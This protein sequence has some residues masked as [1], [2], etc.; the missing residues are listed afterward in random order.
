M[1]YTKAIYF[2]IDEFFRE[3]NSSNHDRIND[4]NV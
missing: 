4:K 2:K 1:S 3:N